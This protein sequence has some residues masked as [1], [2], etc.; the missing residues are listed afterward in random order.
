MRCVDVAC[1]E[2]FS[3]VLAASEQ[4]NKLGYY[5]MKEFYSG[6]LENAKEKINKIRNFYNRKIEKTIGNEH[7]QQQQSQRTV[8]MMGSHSEMS[9]RVRSHQHSHFNLAPSDVK[10]LKQKPSLD[11]QRV[12]KEQAQLSKSETFHIGR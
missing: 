12:V 8:S 11:V 9:L 1:G 3:V 5:N 7:S 6:I 4:R 2:N 10:K